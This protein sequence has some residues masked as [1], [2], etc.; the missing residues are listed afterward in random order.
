[1]LNLLDIF[2]NHSTILTG[3]TPI[4]TGDV[5][6][7]SN[8]ILGLIFLILLT[9]CIIVFYTGITELLPNLYW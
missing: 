7:K 5:L 4:L 1:M 3:N 6:A 8:C 9:I 2:S